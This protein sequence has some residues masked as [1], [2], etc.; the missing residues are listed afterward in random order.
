MN[1]SLNQQAKI[2]LA[3][4][5][6]ATGS[7]AALLWR[8]TASVSERA[9]AAPAV[10]TRDHAPLLAAT[11]PAPEVAPIQ[12]RV[13]QAYTPQAI[14]AAKPSTSEETAEV[15]PDDVAPTTVVTP[16]KR[17]I[18]KKIVLPI[19]ET[20]L[21]SVEPPVD[22]SVFTIQPPEPMPEPP[23]AKPKPKPV[24]DFAPPSHLET[25]EKPKNL[26]VRPLPP[27][28]AEVMVPLTRLDNPVPPMEVMVPFVQFEGDQKTLLDGVAPMVPVRVLPQETDTNE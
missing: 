14:K 24:V 10:V 28:T 16:A 6:L 2:V 13:A 9:D 8:K 21:E 3:A 19:E 22:S 15:P 4:V 5:V 23:A 7:G 11:P 12:E 17:Q 27:V 26:L 18:A 20:P 1:L 25:E